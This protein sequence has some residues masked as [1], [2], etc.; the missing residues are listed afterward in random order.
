MGLHVLFYDVSTEYYS[1]MYVSITYSILDRVR[2]F[3]SNGGRMHTQC[4]R[5]DGSEVQMTDGMS[6]LGKPMVVLAVLTKFM[7]HAISVQRQA[8]TKTPT[9]LQ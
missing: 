8:A 1:M 6:K 9:D 2:A 5:T 3:A 7:F 4:S